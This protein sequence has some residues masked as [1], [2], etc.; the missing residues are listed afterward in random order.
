MKEVMRDWALK[1]ISLSLL[2]SFGCFKHQEHEVIEP[3]W[4]RY[5]LGG[6]VVDSITKEPVDGC[7][8]TVRAVLLMYAGVDTFK[9]AT[10]VT[11]SSGTFLFESIP[12]GAHFISF[13]K[14]EYCTYTTRIMVY[15]RDS[16]NY[17]WPLVKIADM[18]VIRVSPGSFNVTLPVKGHCTRKLT[19]YNA[20]RYINLHWSLGVWSTVEWLD[21][22]GNTGGLIAP[23]QDQKVS[24]YFH[25][26]SGEMIPGEYFFT[27]LVI[28][29]NDPSQPFIVIPVSLGIVPEKPELDKP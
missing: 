12:P 17:R 18:P 14:E 11:D 16:L 13:E 25:H 29:S 19:I 26:I 7:L 24:L 9:S 28:N 2:F 10:T 5:K 22:K 23:G 1:V 3:E 15:F 27:K 6:V 21:V 8:I 20:G 4:P